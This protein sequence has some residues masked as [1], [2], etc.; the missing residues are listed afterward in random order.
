MQ[1]KLNRDP[2]FMSNFVR[3]FGVRYYLSY[4]NNN[5]LNSSVNSFYVGFG[6]YSGCH[7]LENNTS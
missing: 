2:R 7:R 1:P 3:L 6:M 5:K 4:M